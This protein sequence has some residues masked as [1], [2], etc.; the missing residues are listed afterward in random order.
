M[1]DQHADD[2]RGQRRTDHNVDCF[3]AVPVP[4]VSLEGS[5]HDGL[6]K[7]RSRSQRR[8]GS[9]CRFSAKAFHDRGPCPEVA[10]DTRRLTALTN[11]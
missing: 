8:F 7:E 9:R 2:A 4:H 6:H 1:I 10:D 3:E 11:G 5:L